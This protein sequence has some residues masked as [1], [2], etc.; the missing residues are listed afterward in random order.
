MSDSQI[1]KYLLENKLAIDKSQYKNG[2]I[3]ARAYV[4]LINHWCH[5]LILT[6]SQIAVIVMYSS[7]LFCVTAST[8]ASVQ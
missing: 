8:Q 6:I 4:M 1:R 3:P 7:T 5:K 2:K